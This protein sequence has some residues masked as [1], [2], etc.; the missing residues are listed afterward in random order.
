[1]K[2]VGFR[3]YCHCSSDQFTVVKN[4]VL[5]LRT[6]LWL[7]R[8]GSDQRNQRRLTIITSHNTHGHKSFS[9]RA[10]YEHSQESIAVES[11]ASVSRQWTLLKVKL[12]SAGPPL[13]T[14]RHA[15]QW[16]SNMA[17]QI[18]GATLGGGEEMIIWSNYGLDL[19]LPLSPLSLS[20]FLGVCWLGT[21]ASTKQNEYHQVHIDHS[22][23]NHS[24]ARAWL[25]S[26]ISLKIINHSN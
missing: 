11:V 8:L 4:A 2:F 13:N 19:V 3:S 15:A 23:H 10:L 26:I 6:E 20:R 21:F 22:H 25:C 24:R 17:Y 12:I 9:I 1:M 5:N 18:S 14:A 16:P 7:N